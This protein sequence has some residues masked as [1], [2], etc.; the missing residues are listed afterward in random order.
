MKTLL[1]TAA[2]LA[3]VST[4]DAKAQWS[5]R[6]NVDFNDCYNLAE[7][8]AS[9]RPAEWQNIHNQCMSERGHYSDNLDISRKG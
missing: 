2:L 6:Y 8:Y 3:S 5:V 1:F 4:V 7:Y 9:D